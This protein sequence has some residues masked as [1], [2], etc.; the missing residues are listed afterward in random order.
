M[1]ITDKQTKIPSGKIWVGSSTGGGV[2][3]TLSGSIAVSNTGVASLSTNLAK[4]YIPLFL[5]TARIL[6]SDVTTA[7]AVASGNGGNLALDT[8]PI[9]ERVNGATDI[10]FRLRWAAGSAVEVQWQ[11]PYPP[12][13][14]DTADLTVN[15]LANM[16]GATDTPTISVKYFEGVGDTTA[17]GATGALS[18][19]VA[20]VSR[21]IT[22]ANIGAYPNVASVSLV[23]GTHGTDALH[24]YGAWIEY[25]RKN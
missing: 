6:A 2:A 23:P 24:L 8:A 22:A 1:P 20:Q 10:Q 15:L 12:D 5:P 18:T 16:A 11:F 3:R 7:L 21:T 14:D 4:G 13:L 17:G 19:T 25:T 9:F